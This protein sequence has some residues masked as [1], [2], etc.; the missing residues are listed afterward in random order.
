MF[1][2][3]VSKTPVKVVVTTPLY[4]P[5]WN[6]TVTVSKGTLEVVKIPLGIRGKNTEK[7]I[8]SELLN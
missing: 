1:I 3:T 5:K 2:T 6:A 8:Y 7:V 4:D